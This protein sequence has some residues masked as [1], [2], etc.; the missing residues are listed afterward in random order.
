[1]SEKKV[2]ETLEKNPTGLSI[3][4]IAERLKLHRNTIAKIIKKLEENGK[5]E[6]KKVG[7]SKV[8]Y[9]KRYSGLHKLQLGY[10]GKNIS[11]GIGVSDLEDGYKAG[12]SAAKQAAMQSSKGEQPTFSLV[13]VSSKYN[14]QIK[15]VVRGINTILSTN[16]V[17]CT[18]DRELNSVLGYSEGT[19][20]VLCIDTKY[21]H[22]GVGLVDNYRKN[23]Q[24][25][26]RDATMEAI[27][28]C[29]VNRS[30]FATTQFM[31]G[32]KKA[33]VDIIRNPPY[34]VLTFPGGSYYFKSKQPI[35]GMESEFLDG[36]INA[37]GPN[38]PIIGAT[39]SSDVIKVMKE[40]VGDNYQFAYGKVYSKASIVIFIVSDLYFSCGLEHGYKQT[41]R[42]AQLTK[43]TGNNRVIEKINNKNAV[44]EYCRLINV[45][46]REFLKNPW[47]YTLINPVALIDADGNTYIKTIG[48]NPDG[49]TLYSLAK[50]IE[51]S[52]IEILSFN[53]KTVVNALS[54]AVSQSRKGYEDK[55]IVFTLVSSCSARRLVLGDKITPVLKVFKSKHGEVPFFGFYSFGEIGSRK[56]RQPQYNNQTVTTLVIYDD[57]LVQ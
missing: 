50:L 26:G 51:N 20:E 33:F 47:S 37:V 52:N 24:K 30:I 2:L 29:P 38:I 42:I 21:M 6:L 22:F 16:W 8:Y 13:F 7:L 15:E 31:R 10:Q 9:L 36:I 57:L 39:A 18:T 23:P 56:N 54:D 43:V 40:N 1:M 46:K 5:I 28:N 3:T 19:V 35:I 41:P 53:G 34:F 44:E 4:K 14:P 45:N 48:P 25:A 12:V 17:G 27:E 55:N 32:T 11:V 49:K